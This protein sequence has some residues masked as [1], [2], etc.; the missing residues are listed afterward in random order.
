MPPAK[1]QKTAGVYFKDVKDIKY[2]GPDSND[3]LA[4][5]YYNADEVIM[6]KKM[7]DWLRKQLGEE[8][9]VS[10][11]SRGDLWRVV[12]ELT[13]TLKNLQCIT[14]NPDWIKELP[15][16]MGADSPDQMQ[17]RA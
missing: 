10:R 2:V 9:D 11:I 3:P 8:V 6:G 15:D 5:K 17:W 14:R 7:K 16:Q 13:R 4:F 1:K 12:T